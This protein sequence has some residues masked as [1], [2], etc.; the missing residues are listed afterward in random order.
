MNNLTTEQI[1]RVFAMYYGQ[2]YISDPNGE[3]PQN[4]PV[5]GET[6]TCFEYYPNSKCGDV[7]LL[8]PLS[9]ITDEDALEVAKI[10]AQRPPHYGLHDADIT[11]NGTVVDVV[12]L[13]K[14]HEVISIGLNGDNL[15]YVWE[16]DGTRSILERV[17]G[18][19]MAYQYLTQQ[20]YAVPLFIAPGH[21][22][23]GKTAIELGLA[24]DASKVPQP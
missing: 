24:I 2:R 21:P 4:F 7:L 22:D 1:A 6:L 9:S 20:G 16:S 3:E 17:K 8:R 19:P 5:I 11:R 13:D 12:F 10:I 15:L 23:N 14:S 18:Q